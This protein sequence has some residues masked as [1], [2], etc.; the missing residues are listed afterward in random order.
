MMLY[1]ALQYPFQ[2]KGWF[3][4]IL[5]LALVQLL[6]IVGQLILLGYGMDIARALYAGQTS[7]PPIRWLSALGNGFR[8]FLAGFVYLLPIFV[9][10]GV[11]GAS[12]MSSSSSFGNLGVLGIFLAV[13]LPLLL[14]LIR[15]VLVRRTSSPSVQ[16][17]QTRGGGLRSLLSWLLPIFLTIASIFILRTL[18]SSSG[19]DTGKPNGLSILLLVV[20]AFLLFLIGIVLYVGGVR[21]SIENKGLLAP[22]TNAK[23]LLKNRALTGM[24]LLNI[25]LLYAMAIIAT[26]IGLVLFI[27]PGLF[28]FVVCS[29]ALWYMFAYYS[30]EVGV[31]KTSSISK[32]STMS[33]S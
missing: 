24:L 25:I 22:M 8:F 26:T 18:V 20:F 3:R 11:V 6:P 9:T 29:L 1:K 23:L 30:M 12:R 14:F 13:G 16:R 17:S 10:I 27:L 2:G 4:C 32:K 19:I 5:I 33:I 31:N 15:I 7:L 28:V 21:Y